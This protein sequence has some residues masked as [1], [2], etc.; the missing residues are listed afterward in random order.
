[1]NDKLYVGDQEFPG[2]LQVV[3]LST[4]NEPLPLEALRDA[5]TRLDRG[6]RTL[7]GTMKVSPASVR[8]LKQLLYGYKDKQRKQLYKRRFSHLTKRQF[9]R[10]LI[11]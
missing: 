3:S 10:I 1:M 9:E 11:K 2:L 4:Q 5:F 8:M 7:S 6:A